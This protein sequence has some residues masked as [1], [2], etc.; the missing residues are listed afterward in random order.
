[1]VYRERFF[2]SLLTVSIHNFLFSFIP[3]SFLSFPHFFPFLP[4]FLSFLPSSLPSFP[5]FLPSVRPSFFPSFLP[6]FLPSF[7]PSFLSINNIRCTQ[8]KQARL[9]WFLLHFQN[10]GLSWENNLCGQTLLKL[11]SR[12]NA[13]IAKFLRLFDFIPPEFCFDKKQVQLKYGDV[14]TEFSYCISRNFTKWKSMQS[15]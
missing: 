7:L 12:G 15:Q 4:S 1:M 8:T 10:G 11:V 2:H 13:I 6:T 14:L 3:S 9:M 5:S